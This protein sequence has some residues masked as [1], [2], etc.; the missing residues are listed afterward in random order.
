MTRR[1]D[2]IGVLKIRNF[3]RITKPPRE[4]Q[5]KTPKWNLFPLPCLPGRCRKTHSLI[6]V[7]DGRTSRNR[8]LCLKVSDRQRNLSH[9]YQ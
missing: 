6:P 2:K 4:R 7:R 3:L 1:K 8:N 5:E 9:A